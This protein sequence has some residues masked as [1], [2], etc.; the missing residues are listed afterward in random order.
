[1][2]KKKDYKKMTKTQLL[3][4]KRKITNKLNNLMKSIEFDRKYSNENLLDNKHCKKDEYRNALRN[5]DEVLNG[6][7]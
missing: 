4:A 1:M 7:N 2:S 5:I 3:G 6:S